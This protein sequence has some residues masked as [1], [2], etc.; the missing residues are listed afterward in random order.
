[1]LVFSHGHAARGL[2]ARWLDLP[3]DH[4]PLFSLDTA[5]ISVLGSERESPTVARWNS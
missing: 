5:T 2:A 3:V 1:M 4:G